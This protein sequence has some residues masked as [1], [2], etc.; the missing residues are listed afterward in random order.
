MLTLLI[1]PS[2]KLQNRI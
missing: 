1:D 2:W